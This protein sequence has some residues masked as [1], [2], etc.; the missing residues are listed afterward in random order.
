MR[1]TGETASFFIRDG[2]QRICLFRENSPRPI[3]HHLEEGTRHPLNRGAVGQILRAYAAPARDAGVVQKKGWIISRG[4]RE[5]D[6]AGVAVPV[7]N[8][9]RQFVGALSVSGLLSRFS[10]DACEKTKAAL[11]KEA[12]QLPERIP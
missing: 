3:R 10:L 9:E 4:A 1:T 8:R 6:L 7:F 11:L 12:R 2:H 5:P